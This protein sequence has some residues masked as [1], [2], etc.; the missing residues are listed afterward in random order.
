MEYNKSLIQL[1]RLLRYL[2]SHL[3]NKQIIYLLAFIIGVGSGFAAVILKNAIN[4]IKYVLTS[5]FSGFN[6]LLYLAYPGI[7]ILLTILFIKYVVK[8][9]ISYGITK[10][11]YA[12]SRKKSAIKPH[13][14]CTSI[15]ASA[16]TI[17]FGGSVGAEAPIVLT[18][19]AVGSNIGK[20]FKLNYQQIT[21]L[22]GCGAA[23]ATASIFKA[24]LAG[25]LFTLEILMLDLTLSSIIPL[26]ISSLAATSISYFFL[27]YDVSFTHMIT[28]YSVSHL[29]YYALLGVFCG[30]IAVYFT[31]MTG[32][33]ERRLGKI[34]QPL[35][36]WL[37]GSIVLGILIYFIPPLYG[38]GYDIL[39]AL[40]NHNTEQ[41]FE[42]KFFSIFTDNFWLITLYLLVI[43]IF[44][45]IAMALT[46]GSGGIGG[47]FGPSL[48]LGGITGFFLSR[49]MNA[50]QLVTVPEANFTLVGMASLMA[51]VLHAPL[52]A[53]F[54][55]AEITGGYSLFIPLII[56]SAISF[57][58]TRSFETYPLFAKRLVESGDIITHH[59]DKAAITLLDIR[60][61]IETNFT[62]VAK[63]DS[64]GDLVKT[65][66]L[67]TR[68]VF[69]VLDSDKSILGIVMLDDIREI[70]FQTEKYS[71]Y[72]VYDVMKP[73][74]AIIKLSEQT[75]EIID[76]FEQTEAW[77]LPVVD[78]N[79]K[80]IG[81]LSKSKIYTEYRNL[82]KTFSYD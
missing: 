64:L 14:M 54:L 74:P 16:F 71:T 3:T 78:S 7:G 75:D 73:A 33:V 15:V 69:P 59:K 11:L 65:I 57:I 56:A 34:N 22:I 41:I 5:W 80:Y 45:V 55:I 48:F 31:R 62:P 63:N 50:S 1:Q 26:L 2:A 28:S 30:F 52:T 82:L 67:S 32:N 72:F 44:K 68:N 46:T 8:D 39:N 29:P 12:I 79:N 60:K 70:M 76:K 58:T 19:S 37:Y 10:V 49:L 36:R 43:I 25:I 4:F 23:G 38:E 81:F 35:K 13:N 42:H 27:G 51:G 9:N 21:L 77:N 20:L 40:L 61:L 17:G 24:P 6:S 47:I 53:I 66:S 18:G